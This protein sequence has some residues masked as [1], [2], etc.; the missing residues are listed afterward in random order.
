MKKAS[1]FRLSEPDLLPYSYEVVKAQLPYPEDE[2][3]YTEMSRTHMHQH[4]PKQLWSSTAVT[5]PI[6]E[7]RNLPT[8]SRLVTSLEYIL[9]ILRSHYCIVVIR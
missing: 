6:Q 9:L 7:R 3:F 1:H 8:V 4:K 5:P 2:K